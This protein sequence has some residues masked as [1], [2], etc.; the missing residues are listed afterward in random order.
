M[1]LTSQQGYDVL[2]KHR[3]YITEICDA[4]GKLLAAVRYTRHGEIGEWCSRECRGDQPKHSIRKAGRPPKYETAAARRQAERRQNTQRQRAFR[5]RV[6]R[7]GKPTR[8]LA[9]TKDLQA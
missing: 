2:V 6:Q 9:K 8:S 3:S 1:M 5:E 7:N 4:C